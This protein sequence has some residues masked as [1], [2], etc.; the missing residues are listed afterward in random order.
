MS[1][2]TPSHPG[3]SYPSFDLF[4]QLD[5]LI[6]LKDISPINNIIHDNNIL[7]DLIYCSCFVL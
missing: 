6:F 1:V 5:L 2:L 3:H 7:I 4:V